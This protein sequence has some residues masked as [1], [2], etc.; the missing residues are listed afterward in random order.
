MLYLISQVKVS[1]R[2]ASQWIIVSIS[3]LFFSFMFTLV[4]SAQSTNIEMPDLINEEGVHFI[5]ESVIAYREI[6]DQEPDN[7]SIFVLLAHIENETDK[8]Q[9]IYAEDLSLVLDGEEFEPDGGL[10][11]AVKPLLTPERDYVGSWWGHCA[12]KRSTELTYVVFDVPPNSKN[13]GL[14]FGNQTVD[15]GITWHIGIYPIGEELEFNT[16]GDL[17][18]M[19]ADSEATLTVAMQTQR[20][21]ATATMQMQR[22]N[23]TATMQ[24]QRANATATATLWTPTNTHQ[25][26]ATPTIT[27]TPQPTV[28]TGGTTYYTSNSGINARE[29]PETTCAVLQVLSAGVEVRVTDTVQGTSVGGNRRWYQAVRN[30]QII[31]IHTSL[32]SRTRPATPRPAPQTSRG[33]TSNVQNQSQSSAP[34]YSCNCS[35]TCGSMTCEEAYFQLQQCGCSR[36]DSDKDGVPC[37]NICPGG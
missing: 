36:R 7:G 34:Q 31:Y 27:N 21:N 30:G 13:V 28:P 10:M 17:A 5:V 33:Q 14:R 37:E 29:C 24:M 4:F 2:G 8:R 19:R 18:T 6:E 25:P 11:D 12:D 3:L 22:A 35:K 26:S 16:L 1:N 32:L 9:C 20:A 23:A 15:M